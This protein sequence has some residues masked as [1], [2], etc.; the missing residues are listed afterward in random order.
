MNIPT[1]DREIDALLAEFEACATYAE[2][3][4]LRS[5]CVQ[6]L[7]SYVPGVGV[8]PN[9]AAQWTEFE[10]ITRKV[11]AEIKVREYDSIKTYSVKELVAMA[12]AKQSEA[13]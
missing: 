9:R 7:D 3:M 8:G 10:R 12:A 6:A 2:Y 11:S 1:L 13:A 5:R 4:P